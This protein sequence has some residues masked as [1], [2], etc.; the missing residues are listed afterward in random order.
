M[1]KKLIIF[2]IICI[3]FNTFC[4][5]G[6]STII[7]KIKNL[8]D[9]QLN[10]L[11]EKNTNSSTTTKKVDKQAE[12]IKEQNKVKILQ[13]SFDSVNNSE[14]E[15]NIKTKDGNFDTADQEPAPLNEDDFDEREE[16][17]NEDFSV[18]NIKPKLN[19]FGY[20]IF[21]SGPKTFENSTTGTLD[22]SY[23]IGSGDEIIIMLWGETEFNESFVVTKDGYLFIE[24]L[25]QVFVN[26]LTL[27]RLEQKLFN[28]YKKV[29]SSMDSLNGEPSTFFDISLGSSVL[30]PK[31][32]FVVGEVDKPGAYFVNQ[33]TSLYTS[34]YYFGGPQVS[35]SLR[36]IRLIR[37]GKQISSIDFYDFLLTGETKNDIRLLRDD[38]IFIPPRLKTI[39][40]AGEIRRDGI[41]EMK[42][43]E[44][45]KDIIKIAGGLKNTTYRKR[46][47]IDRIL[48]PKTRIE[49]NMNRI[50]IDLDLKKLMTEDSDF[51]LFDDDS[52]SFFKITENVGNAVEIRG[53]V[54]RPGKYSLGR[55]MTIKEILNKADG[56]LANAFMERGEIIRTNND[57]TTSLIDINLEKAIKNDLS[58]NVKL[59][60]NDIITI[61]NYDAMTF[62]SGFEIRGHVK[63]PSFHPFRNNTTLYDLVFKGGGFENEEH[64]K[65]TYFEKAILTRKNEKNFA[66]EDIPFRVDSV[67][68][69]K[70]LANE[71]LKMGD[72]VT[73]FSIDQIYGQLNNTVEISGFVKRPGVYPKSEGMRLT[74]LFFLGGGDQDSTFLSSLFKDRADLIRYDLSSKTSKIIPI[75]L[76]KILLND[77]T[78]HN[79]L[80][81]KG[82]IFR[83]YSN[84]IFNFSEYV[85]IA[86]SVQSPSRYILK[87]NMTIIDLIL[88][89]GGVGDDIFNFQYEIARINPKNMD[90]LQYAKIIK[91][92]IINSA[93]S[94]F[95]EN[96]NSKI[97]LAPYDLVIIRPNP[98]FKRQSLINIDGYV[99]YPGDYVLTSPKEK[100]TDLLKR[101][102]GL[103]EDA[104]P[105]ASRVVRNDEN[106]NV[107]LNEI[108][109]FPN[110]RKNFYVMEGDSIYIGSRPNLIK[111][112]G[113]VSTPG[114]YQYIKGK[115]FKDYIKSAGG[116]TKDAAKS[117]TI[118]RLPNGRTKKMNI[119]SFSPKIL[120][121]SEIIVGRKEEVEPFSVTEYV[122]NL[123]QIYA[124]LSQAYIMILLATR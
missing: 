51:D 107:S 2:Y 108:I 27:K 100:V 86:G 37:S 83:I 9:S 60:V 4:Q 16:I 14:S 90:N 48:D 44:T 75:N 101:A 88:E 28:L 29:H 3:S 82:D 114:N 76:K 42:D 110:S 104:Y 24:N 116:M 31:R 55:G 92:N 20:D 84:E 12:L 121:G 13:D 106:L 78:E 36:D 25:G 72:K 30:K 71:I 64:L 79:F 19:Y 69:G 124:D 80:L 15:I 66:I 113:E 102:G 18:I 68:I 98:Y 123:T 63:N 58:H 1:Y 65:N 17:S 62:R 52:I 21:S 97:L 6:N 46:I 32:I 38:V 10:E 95:S 103:R 26:G 74:D 7:N 111:I 89:A 67:L 73:I 47:Q 94:Y 50:L 39:K 105:H 22:P 122:S 45:L 120:D 115:S 43:N 23:V 34:L 99:L 57:N 61:F 119:F 5:V 77:K 112:S 8:S 11:I 117:A 54:N 59:K 91:G 93:E 35:G 49:K 85:T 109:T 81:K 56:L 87:E 40:V 70:G 41:F 53:S 118:I 33:S 96:K